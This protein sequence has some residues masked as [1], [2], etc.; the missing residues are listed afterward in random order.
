MISHAESRV[1]PLFKLFRK[2]WKYLTAKLSGDFDQR[3]DPKVQIEQ[4]I[5]EAKTQHVRLKE[6]AANVIANQ[7]QGEI[8]LNG[9]LTELEKLNANARQALIM[10]SDAEQAGDTV[11]AAQYNSAAETIANQLI[12]IEKDVTGLKTMV[13]EAAQAS[14]QAKAAVQQNSR[15]LQEKIA[16]KSK[17]L[18]QLDQAKMREQMNSAMAQLSESIGADVPTFKE[19]EEKIQLRFAKAQATSELAGSSVEVRVLEVE[20][21]TANVEAHSRLSQLRSELGLDTAPSSQ[22]VR[23]VSTGSSS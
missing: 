22:P 17:L 18:S 14:D 2:W 23:E 20:Q 1:N 3:A 7:K 16:Q 5:G 9:K 6:Q 8:R 12:Q 19:L 15:L 10:A 21:A 4:A 11:K 13:L